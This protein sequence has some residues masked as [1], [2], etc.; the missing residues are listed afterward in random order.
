MD[1]D[2]CVK[3]SSVLQERQPTFLPTSSLNVVLPLRQSH[4]SA[5]V[6]RKH[7]TTVFYD[8]STAYAFESM[9]TPGAITLIVVASAKT[10]MSVRLCK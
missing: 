6:A 2:C 7:F 9:S 1:R 4:Q 10:D 8:K 5:L 3:S